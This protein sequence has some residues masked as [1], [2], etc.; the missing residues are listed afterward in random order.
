[1]KPTPK[2]PVV[3]VANNPLGHHLLTSQL[4]HTYE[5]MDLDTEVIIL[6]NGVMPHADSGQVPW[7]RVVSFG[8]S[9]GS[10]IAYA[11]LVAALIRL[12]VSHPQAVYHLRG[13]VTAAFFC[14]SR[15]GM[16]RRA[17]YVYD[18]R[19]AFAV[20]WR[21][22]ERPRG[23]GGILRR[24]EKHLVRNSS[25]TIVTSERFKQFYQQ[26]FGVGPT[27]VTV[28]NS[29]SFPFRGSEWSL[30]TD[31]PTR[32]V[33]LGTFNHWHAMDEVARVMTQAAR[34][35]GPERVELFVY[36]L[37]RF[38]DAVRE[39][40]GVIDCAGLTV[41]YVRYEDLPSVL[42]D[43]HIGVSVVR[44]TPSSRIASPIK[45]ADYVALGVVPL[46]NRGIGDFDA[47][48]LSNKS[49]VLYEFGEDID[50]TGLADIST[51][52]NRQIYDVVSQ[53][54]ALKRLAPVLERLRHG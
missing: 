47:H 36:T 27:Y 45:V 13:F 46:M 29:T 28:Y 5:A 22:A 31:G 30:P 3:L 6:C 37:P 48:F 51:T 19:G 44:P 20:E 10:A 11:R 34:Q 21:E 9:R 39:T 54:E 8:T 18:P 24:W 2:R 23:V 49:G 35:L 4:L 53:A 50:L 1:M 38:H 12:R 26:Q 7:A 33:Y 43:K 52:T 42:V 40:F 17:R 16:L 14:L 41:D 25:T 32:I 15:G